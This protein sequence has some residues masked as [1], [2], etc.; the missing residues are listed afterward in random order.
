[1]TSTDPFDGALRRTEELREFY[2]TAMERAVRKDIGYLDDM[3]RRRGDQAPAAA[4]PAA[5]PPFMFRA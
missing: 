5:P 3:C 2:E 4:Q 1:M